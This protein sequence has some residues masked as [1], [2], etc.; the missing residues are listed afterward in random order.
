EHKPHTVG[1][2][3]TMLRR[4]ANKADEAWTDNAGDLAALDVIRKIAGIAV[5]CMEDWGAPLRK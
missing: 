4:Y 1:N 5:H 2:Y 3:L